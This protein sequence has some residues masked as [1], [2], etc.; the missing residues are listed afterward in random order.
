MKDLNRESDG[1]RDLPAHPG[2]RSDATLTI[3]SLAT[4]SM[5]GTALLVVGGLA[6][7]MKADTPFFALSRNAALASM[8]VGG[9]LDA[10]A[11]I[12]L[13]RFQRNHGGS[14]LR[15]GSDGA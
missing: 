13:V 4:L 7:F 10:V 11:S 1:R 8:V 2:V 9:V 12:Q 14:A 6:W 5:L 3:V 15:R